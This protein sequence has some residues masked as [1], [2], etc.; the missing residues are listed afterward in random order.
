VLGGAP[1]P[2][3]AEHDGGLLWEAGAA[4]G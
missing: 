2:W 4:A 1:G 3:G